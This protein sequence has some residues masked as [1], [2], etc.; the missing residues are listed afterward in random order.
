MNFRQFFIA[1]L[2][3]SFFTAAI[4][5][6]VFYTWFKPNLIAALESVNNTN[7]AD[8]SRSLA[9]QASSLDGSGLSTEND[10]IVE[11]VGRVNPAVVSIVVSKDMPI[12]E[13]YYENLD[14]WG[15]FTVPRTRESGSEEREIGGGSGFIA[16]ADGLVVT[17]R[18]VVNDEKAKYTVVLSDGTTYNVDILAVD[19]QLDVAVLKINNLATGVKLPFLSFGDSENL[20]LGERV[21]AIGNALAEFKNS[22]SVG[23]VS[24]LSRSIVASDQFGKSE[25]L[26]QVIQTDAAINPGNSGGPLLNLKGEVIG[27]N[28]ATSQRADNIGFALPASL[29][30]GIVESV[31]VHG[32]IVSPFLGVRYMVIDEVVQKRNNLS[33]DYGVLIVR[34]REDSDLAVVP[35]SPADKAGLTENDIILAIDGEELRNRDLIT[36]LRSKEIGKEI[37]LEVL[38]KGERKTLKVTLIAT[39]ETPLS[40]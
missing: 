4:L 17:N 25:S 3:S 11:M 18:H 34:G 24:G 26:D 20:R 9:R 7:S 37:T 5:V 33:V 16:S 32:R 22:V 21:V 1:S 13:Q 36:I 10:L 35:G 38:Q 30:S 29:V 39:P 28:V 2:L 8:I 12:Y 6:M 15:M 31:K 40:R 27:I 23:V 19:S 14:P